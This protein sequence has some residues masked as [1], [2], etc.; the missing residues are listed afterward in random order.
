MNKP[1]IDTV[2]G[3]VANNIHN[4]SVTFLAPQLPPPPPENEAKLKDI[5]PKV[6]HAQIDLALTH[7]D[8]TAKEILTAWKAKALGCKRGELVHQFKKLDQ[9]CL[10][11]LL[12]FLGAYLVALGV[13]LFLPGLSELSRNK[14]WATLVATGMLMAISTVHLLR[15]H[16]IAHLTILSIQQHAGEK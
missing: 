3:Q 11:L 4:A 13:A 6:C 5:V 7:G 16:K 12:V 9:W 2:N 8:V 14:A 10:G 1:E 15:P